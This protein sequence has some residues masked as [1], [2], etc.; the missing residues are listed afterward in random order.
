[1]PRDKYV[2]NMD[3]ERRFFTQAWK[4]KREQLTTI[5]IYSFEPVEP[6]DA[7]IFGAVA[8]EELQAWAK[9]V[10]SARGNDEKTIATRLD[11]V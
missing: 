8:M 2:K 3:R 1:M 6:E 7:E 4:D 11:L 9:E 5:D 10:E